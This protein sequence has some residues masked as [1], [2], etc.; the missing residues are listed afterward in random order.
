MT[1]YVVQ[2]P[3]NFDRL[4]GKHTSKFDMSS[5]SEFGPVEVLINW[6]AKPWDGTV[7]KELRH[8]LSRFGP[9]DWLIL[10]GNP[11]LMG[12]AAAIVADYCDGQLR[13]LQYNGREGR[14]LP[15]VLETYGHGD[16]SGDL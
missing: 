13:L 3:Q 15:V 14:Y 5:A 12:A 2:E 16:E 4:T 1:V 9:G 6:T 10:A 7:V 11:C 8:K